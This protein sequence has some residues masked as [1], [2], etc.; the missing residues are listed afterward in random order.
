MKLGV[1]MMPLH[2]PEKDRWLQGFDAN[3]SS[4]IAVRT[5][6]GIHAWEG[7]IVADQGQGGRGI[8]FSCNCLKNFLPLYYELTNSMRNSK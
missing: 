4:E 8:F 2:P 7:P 3:E 6:G 5:L 1:F